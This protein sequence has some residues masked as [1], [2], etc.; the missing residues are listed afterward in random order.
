[1]REAY[2]LRTSVGVG[3]LTCIVFSGCGLG[4][5]DGAAP[6]TIFD[7][8][9][10]ISDD[11]AYRSAQLDPTTLA[12]VLETHAIRTIVNLRGPN[13]DKLWYQNEKRVADEM[14]VTLVD[15]PMSASRLPPRDVLLQIYDAFES[16]EYPILIHCQAGA[17]R[18]GAA[19]AIWRMTVESAPRE[20][21]STELSLLSGHF[22]ARHPEM[23]RLVAMYEPS[24]EWILNE[25][26]VD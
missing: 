16:A 9:R 19:A 7:N 23:D 3:L 5:N 18:T 21:A 13:E 15:I 2:G 26:P 6:L 22:A 14:G 10:V 8:F 1:M 17:D 24:R 20:A 4:A 12:L 11:K 25:Y